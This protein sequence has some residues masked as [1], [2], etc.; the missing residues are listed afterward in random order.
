MLPLA[1]ILLT[2]AQDAGRPNSDFTPALDHASRSVSEWSLLLDDERE[3]ANAAWCLY[4]ADDRSSAVVEALKLALATPL[5]P[6]AH[7]PIDTILCE[8]G[9]AFEALLTDAFSANRRAL[10]AS[11]L[12]PPPP[13]GPAATARLARDEDADAALAELVDLLGGGEL[14]APTKQW[15][16][17]HAGRGLGAEVG[18]RITARLRADG[19]KAIGIRRWLDEIAGCRSCLQGAAQALGELAASEAETAAAA[20]VLLPKAAAWIG[21]DSIE[22]REFHLPWRASAADEPQIEAA[23]AHHYARLV[24]AAADV[25]HIDRPL[26][27][28]LH[29]RVRAHPAIAVAISPGLLRLLDKSAAY[30]LEVLRLLCHAGCTDPRV[31]EAWLGMARSWSDVSAPALATLPCLPRYDEETRGVLLDLMR[32]AESVAPFV[33]K[34]AFAGEIDADQSSALRY[35]FDHLAND[36]WT[37]LVTNGIRG[38]VDEPAAMPEH[39]RST[40]ATL[41]ER[42]ARLERIALNCATRKLRGLDFGADVAALAEMTELE[43]A[44]CGGHG[45]ADYVASAWSHARKL[46]LHSDALVRSALATLRDAFPHGMAFASH[47]DAA[48]AYLESA[49]LTLAQQVEFERVVPFAAN[50]RRIGGFF[51][52]AA[53]KVV[54]ERV[55]VMRA[56]LYAGDVPV[57][58]ELARVTRL[59]DRDV[60]YL[61]AAMQR[62]PAATR[63]W[64]LELVDS[65]KLGAP[66][67]RDAVLR[68]RDDVDDSVA[69]R[70]RRLADAR[71]W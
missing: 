49:A 61:L 10:L 46:Q 6:T 29:A 31:R 19:N 36:E 26:L 44:S 34:L 30:D 68:R 38:L 11:A 60:D 47:S 28:A 35:A 18:R 21:V 41:S 42:A 3:A 20:A 39:I 25:G 8:W 1:S 27:A 45:Y 23:L 70:A 43:P 55:P 33:D 7:V 37:W 16:H 5:A 17:E 65:E 53:G 50:D 13:S 15:L 59:L 66:R 48:L 22:D 57:L 32:R 54:L 58:E 12:F 2:A 69:R 14:D 52:R 9:V 64:A 40:T 71:G 63:A 62:G 67:V 4:Y 24:D 51:G 56:A